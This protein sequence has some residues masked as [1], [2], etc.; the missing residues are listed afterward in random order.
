MC[1][2]GGGKTG[3]MLGFAGCQLSFRY[4]ERLFQG[5]RDG[6]VVKAPAALSGDLSVV[7]STHVTQPTTV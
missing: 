7:P 1:G 6:S 2:G 5:G 4:V 3:G